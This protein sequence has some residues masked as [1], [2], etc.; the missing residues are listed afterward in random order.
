M[1]T[2]NFRSWLTWTLR[3]ASFRWPPRTEALRAARVSRGRYKCV[4]CEGEFTNKEV[5][6]DHKEPVIDPKRGWQGWDS[7]IERMFC[8]ASGFQIL[9][10]VCHYSKTEKERLVRTE[11]RRKN[12]KSTKD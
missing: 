3:K 1:K 6:V 4:G 2:F 8:P 9:C 10:N 7:F 5:S 12:G 11:N